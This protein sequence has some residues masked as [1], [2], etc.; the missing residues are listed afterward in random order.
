VRRGIN[1]GYFAARPS[2]EMVEAVVCAYLDTLGLEAHHVGVVAT[3]LWVQVLR[4]AALASR[5][6]AH[7]LA[8]RWTREV[9]ALGPTSTIEDIGRVERECRSAIFE[10]IDG[11]YMEVLFRVNAAFSRQ[12]I[13]AQPQYDDPEGYKEFF[14]D[15]KKAKLLELDAIDQGDEIMAVMAALHSRKLWGGR[16]E[17]WERL[18]PQQRGHANIN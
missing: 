12:Q 6:E 1:G 18:H 15:W 13:S 7:E 16:A 4:E 8:E 14:R 2:V 9:E 3:A 10:L 11:A 5:P 17:R